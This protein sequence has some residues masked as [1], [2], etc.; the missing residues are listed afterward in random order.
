MLYAVRFFPYADTPLLVL[1]FAVGTSLLG[2]LVFYQLVES[3]AQRRSSAIRYASEKK[4]LIVP[5]AEP[6]L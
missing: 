1:P 5:A 3:P 4:R 6:R 2:S